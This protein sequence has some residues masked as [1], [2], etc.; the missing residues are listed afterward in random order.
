M[1][2]DHDPDVRLTFE[3]RVRAPGPGPFRVTVR[4]RDGAE[5]D[6]AHVRARTTEVAG[7]ETA[8][9]VVPRPALVGQR[10]EFQVGARAGQDDPALFS[11]WQSSGLR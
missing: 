7:G 8:R 5:T 4:V 2:A 6:P 1:R 9:V 11:R 3:V 10:F